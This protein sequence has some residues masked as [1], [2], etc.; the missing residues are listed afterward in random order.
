MTCK[1]IMEGTGQIPF[2][3]ALS[4]YD[5]LLIL[6]EISSSACIKQTMDYYTVIKKTFPFWKKTSNI[7]FTF[8][9][10]FISIH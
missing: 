5:V 6:N 10:H 2:L 3:T 7:L 9:Y 4:A 8:F 1:A